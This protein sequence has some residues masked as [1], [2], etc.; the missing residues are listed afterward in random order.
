MSAQRRWD[1]AAAATSAGKT[2]DPE[3]L[4]QAEVRGI[5]ADQGSAMAWFREAATLGDLEARARLAHI[6][7]R[8]RP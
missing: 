8:N 6:E 5:Q 4:L 7:S 1:P 2:Y 3:F